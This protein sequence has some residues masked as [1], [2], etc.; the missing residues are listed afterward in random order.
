MGL[1]HPDHRSQ[2]TLARCLPEVIP[3]LG[4]LHRPSIQARGGT[5]LL[6]SDIVLLLEML[7]LLADAIAPTQEVRQFP[8]LSEHRSSNKSEQQ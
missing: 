3:Q 4:Q 5:F 1:H 6:G 2:G 8:V 7:A